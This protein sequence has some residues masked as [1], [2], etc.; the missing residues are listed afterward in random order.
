[1]INDIEYN[2]IIK[3]IQEDII[4]NKI[5]NYSKISTS[6]F[7][8]AK[9][10]NRSDAQTEH[11]AN[12]LLSTFFK[13]KIPGLNDNKN[14]YNN[15]SNLKSDN[16]SG[17]LIIVP[18]IGYI[19]NLLIQNKDKISSDDLLSNIVK[20]ISLVGMCLGI[21]EG[22]EIF[23]LVKQ[24]LSV[25]DVGTSAMQGLLESE[26]KIDKALD[27]G[28]GANLLGGSMISFDYLKN[29][30]IYIWN[31]IQ[32]MYNN[33]IIQKTVEKIKNSI[34]NPDSSSAPEI[35]ENTINEMDKIINGV[36]KKDIKKLEPL[37]NYYFDKS[38][39]KIIYNG[40][41]NFKEI[42]TLISIND[43]FHI[44]SIEMITN[45]DKSIHYLINNSNTKIDS[46]SQIEGNPVHTA[47][48]FA[49]MANKHNIVINEAKKYV[50]KIDDDGSV[51]IYLRNDNKEIC[52]ELP[53]I[54]RA[55][56]LQKDN[57][58]KQGVEYIKKTC[59][60]I[61]GYD[62][63]LSKESCAKHFYSILGRSAINMIQ[64][65]EK[66]IEK[67]PDIYNLL[68][69]ANPG[70]QY[71][72]LKNLD[73]KSK[74]NSENNLELIN[75]E[76]WLTIKND[77]EYKKYLNNK[78]KIKELLSQMILRVNLERGLLEPSKQIEVI[79]N[80]NNKK[81]RIIKKNNINLSKQEIN[82]LQY[83]S[84]ME[85][86]ILS[87][88]NYNQNQIGGQIYSTSNTNFKFFNNLDE[89]YKILKESLE[90]VNKKLSTTT[91]NEIRSK[92]E[93]IKGLQQKLELI[94]N[95]IFNYI[96]IIRNDKK[97]YINNQYLDID[98]I[99]NLIEQYNTY[100]NK[101]NKKYVTISTVFGKLQVILEDYNEHKDRQYY[102][103]I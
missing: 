89:K 62:E 12:G 93:Q 42:R 26:I 13:I 54:T 1:M 79:S 73:W 103:N 75:V 84:L 50:Y 69:L 80:K 76:E 81:R 7:G 61:F 74:K 57:D 96:K 10:T 68:L 11:I 72:I 5:V 6:L 33:S 16:T 44:K 29:V 59:K 55:I 31:S 18:V 36:I 63:G 46:I 9:L 27:L 45:K 56:N 30:G 60:E 14:N 22:M 82:N 32:Q 34:I 90:N 95:K 67:K 41:S 24:F 23:K 88:T 4:N 51:K 48:V 40:E 85:N 3:F 47:L 25:K 77:L 52:N 97:A 37:Y 92:I 17:L 101:K 66:E 100:N 102:H 19:I 58:E 94:Y 86:F 83:L 53:T 78:P 39:G 87:N 38:S 28:G 35:D 43:N 91:D 15:I 98:E 70:I 71:E 20:L 99:D 21:K 2:Q 8:A 65:L 49:Y 64:N